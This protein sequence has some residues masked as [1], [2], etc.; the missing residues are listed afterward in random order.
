MEQK[1]SDK[2]NSKQKEKYNLDEDTSSFS[3]EIEEESNNESEES[4]KQK[5]S[6]KLEESTKNQN[7][8]QLMDKLISIQK[9][10]DTNQN[11]PRYSIYNYKE[12]NN[13]DNNTSKNI[14]KNNSNNN[15]NYFN[16]SG[17]NL[18]ESEEDEYNNNSRSKF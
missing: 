13:T 2:E 11:K 7:S 18:N 8:S 16:K 17:L 12:N 1:K 10:M 14:Y 5:E 15:M 6:P 9:K 3:P 4:S